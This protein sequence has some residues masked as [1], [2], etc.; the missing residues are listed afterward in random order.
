LRR[1]YVIV[2]LV[3]VAGGLRAESLAADGHQATRVTRPGSKHAIR[4]ILIARASV[5]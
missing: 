3:N 4:V 2:P 1:I 5:A